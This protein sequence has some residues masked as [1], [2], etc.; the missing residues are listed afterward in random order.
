MWLSD[1]AAMKDPMGI[2]G[3][4]QPCKT[5]L[6]LDDARSKLLTGF[7]R[8]EKALAASQRGDIREAF[9]YWRLLHDNAFPSYYL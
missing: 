4:I 9:E 2:S 7:T 8:A 5:P 3:L 6:M 1:L